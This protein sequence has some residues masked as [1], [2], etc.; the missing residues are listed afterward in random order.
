MY[1][2]I[3]IASDPEGL[4]ERTVAVVAA[5][6]KD[7]DATV[8]VVAVEPEGSAAV[9]ERVVEHLHRIVTDLRRQGVVADG[10]IQPRYHGHVAEIL[11]AA[12]DR[13]G[14]DLI[15]LGSH[16]HGDLS[17]LFV[18]SVGHAVASRTRTPL[19]FVG[20]ARAAATPQLPP[21]DRRRVLVAVDFDRGSQQAIQAAIGISGPQTRV[22]LIHVHALPQTDP[23]AGHVPADIVEGDRKAVHYLM[24]GALQQLADRGLQASWEVFDRPGTVGHVIARAAEDLDADVIVLG[25]RRLPTA[26]ALI[27]GSTAHDVIALTTRPV[28]LAAAEAE[29]ATTETPAQAAASGDRR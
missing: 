2:R 1:R 12:A 21:T 3:L 16:R 11:V 28:L 29:T 10:I 7:T 19:L 23:A 17:S 8:R 4:A 15:V 14:A 27:A 6:V 26:W 18:G 9:R 22:H 20:S 13:W 24:Q 5:L 25:S